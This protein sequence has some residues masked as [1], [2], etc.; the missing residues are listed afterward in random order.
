MTYLTNLYKI[1]VLIL[2]HV[3]YNIWNNLYIYFEYSE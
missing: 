1:F 2:K 3:V